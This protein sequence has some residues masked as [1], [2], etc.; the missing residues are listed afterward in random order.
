MPKP[1]R[2]QASTILEALIS[3]TIGIILCG[4]ALH[5]M[6]MITKIYYQMQLQC[7]LQTAK[8]IARHY[9]GT[10]L[11]AMI[12][13]PFS[14]QVGSKN[15]AATMPQINMRHLKPLTDV[16]V[17]KTTQ[18][19]VV[20]YLRKSAI[21]QDNNNICYALYRDNIKQNA[22]ALVENISDLQIQLRPATHP[23]YVA[24]IKLTFAQHDELRIIWHFLIDN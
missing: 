20:Y 10:D 17:L 8:L 6:L 14:C 21:H 24:E 12:I 22:V 4:C 5:Y 23:I 2:M 1:F 11:A 16:L 19:N 9:I 13:P 3:T 15:C 7:Q 18:E